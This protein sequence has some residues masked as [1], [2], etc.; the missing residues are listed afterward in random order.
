M[1]ALGL[2]IKSLILVLVS[3]LLLVSLCPKWPGLR[4]MKDIPTPTGE[5]RFSRRLLI[6]LRGPSAG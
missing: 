4:R 2:R 6:F 5:M 1:E 3:V